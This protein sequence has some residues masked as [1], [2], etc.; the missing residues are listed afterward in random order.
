MIPLQAALV[1]RT[2]ALS[3]AAALLAAGPVAKVASKVVSPT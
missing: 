3:T 1:S 2:G